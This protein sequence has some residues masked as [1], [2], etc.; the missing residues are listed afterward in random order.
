VSSAGD[1]FAPILWPLARVSAYNSA[2]K[3]AFRYAGILIVLLGLFRC[4]SVCQ[5]S[6][7]APTQTT[8]PAASAPPAKP[9]TS[10]SKNSK[11]AEKPAQPKLTAKQKQAVDILETVQGELGR[12]S[13]ETQTYLL[14]QMAEAYRPLDPTKQGELLKEAFQS[15]ANMPEGR[16]RTQ[17]QTDI[18][19]AL[20]LADPSALTSMQDSPDPKVREVVLQLLVK[21]DI[22]RGKLEAAAQRLSQWDPSL[23][24]PYESAKQVINRLTAQQA[25][26]RQSVFASAIA[27]YRNGEVEVSPEMEATDFILGTYED[28]PAP[29]VVDAVDVVLNKVAK[30]ELD[31]PEHVS[32][33]AGGKGGN[34]HFS[35]LY[36]LELFELLPVLDKLDRA[37]ADA[38]RRDHAT[39]AAL[40]NKYPNGKSSLSSD[41]KEPGMMFNIGGESD[42]P[43][44]PDPDFVQERLTAATIAD[45]ASKNVDAAITSA[46]GLPNTVRG[47]WD[48][49]TV[50]CNTLEKIATA[51]LGRK[52]FAGA[53][54]GA[55]ALVAAAQDLPALARAHY[56]IEA[57][58]ISAEAHEPQT[59]KQYLARSMK[60]ADELYQADA[61]GET[62]NEA[63]KCVW[64]ST[65]AWKGTLVVA[66]R[67]DPDYAAQEAGSL[68]DPEIEAIANVARATVLLGKEPTMTS[69]IRQVKIDTT[70]LQF[71]IPWWSVG[72]SASGEHQNM[73]AQ[74]AQ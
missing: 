21:Q 41:G 40:N 26:E 39:V 20:N 56:L 64:P 33:S 58:A 6:T 24:F 3:T 38:L 2:V 18:V 11:T 34:A 68:P 28:V 72:S 62:P 60:A 10:S 53:L 1:D 47:N 70:E 71:D 15:A 51:A 54:T 5:S 52:D 27:S 69:I 4:E 8:P 25:G 42:A 46:Q 30:W 12:Y 50:R 67:I 16:Y 55:K 13:P 65:A 19:G 35:S 29:M 43:A 49:M 36:D 7:P 63:P 37:K 14:M 31:K 22:D 17:Q 74:A 48:D 23:A 45:S 32:I 9:T 66:Q 61:F 57:A 59:A 73:N 44:A